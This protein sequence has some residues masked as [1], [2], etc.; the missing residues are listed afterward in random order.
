MN[1]SYES[2]LGT[3]AWVGVRLRALPYPVTRMLLVCDLALGTVLP[4]W[5]WWL[6][7]RWT[8]TRIGFRSYWPIY[9]R[10]FQ[11]AWKHFRRGPSHT[12]L[13]TTDWRSPPMRRTHARERA[14]H[15][16]RGS[17]GA[18]TKCCRTSWLP[19]A[20]QVACPFLGDLG[21]TIYGSLYWDY[22]NCGRYPTGE[23]ELRVYACPRFTFSQADRS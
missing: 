13:W 11:F 18:C 10:S 9:K 20:E 16:P 2:S 1:Q 23:P 22:F 15:S 12:G 19:P 7:R 5:G 3:R 4:L 17:C 21:C 14:D 8:R 6:Y